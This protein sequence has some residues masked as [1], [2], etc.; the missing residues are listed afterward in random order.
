MAYEV[1]MPQLGI[2]MTEGAV[3][4]WLKKPGDAVEKGEPIF[5][6]ETDKVDMEVEATRSGIL[7]E[8]V[9]EPGQVVAVGTVVAK[10]AECINT[11]TPKIPAPANERA[12]AAKTATDLSSELALSPSTTIASSQPKAIHKPG[13]DARPFLASPRAKHVARELNIDISAVPDYDQ[14]GRIVEANIRRFA[15]ERG[16]VNPQDSRASR[17][18]SK[19]L[20]SAARMSV[21]ERMTASF[22]E[23]PH[24]YLDVLADASELTRLRDGVLPQIQ[25]ETGVRL[26]YTDLFLKALAIALRDNPEVNA[27]W[28]DGHILRWPTVNLGIAVQ[29]S[30]RLIVPVVR[31]ADKLPLQALVQA[32]HEAVTSA[33]SGS[34]SEQ[35]LDNASCTLTNLGSYRVDQFHAI[36]NPPQSTILAVGR[37]SPR[38]VVVDGAVVVRQ[39]VHLS[40]SVD[41]R[42]LDGAQAALFLSSVIGVIESPYSLIVE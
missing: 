29:T 35:Y 4:Q 19:D 13:A 36:I 3:R 6:V 40:L 34:L 37:I 24:F 7:S 9:V 11:E 25:R 21:A 28:Q 16:Q 1:V 18:P 15:A 38:P 10:I 27:S 12:P 30:D 17:T 2:T 22:R 33:R 23:T 42:L 41:H 31:D 32:R 20:P 14:R 8:I 39:T 5:I 26:S